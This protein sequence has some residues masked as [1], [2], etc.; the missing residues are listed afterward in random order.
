MSSW[1]GEL[2]CDVCGCH[3]ALFF[4]DGRTKS[5]SWALMCP[6]CWAKFGCGQLGVGS[7]QAYSGTDRTK[8]D[9]AKSNSDLLT[10]ARRQVAEQA[11]RLKKIE[12]AQT[13]LLHRKSQVGNRLDVFQDAQHQLERLTTPIKKVP[14][15]VSGRPQRTSAMPTFNVGGKNLTATEVAKLLREKGVL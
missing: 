4:V 2:K 6:R 7:G 1:L 12:K 14:M 11:A 15:G 5:G 10:W 13:R 3:E 8:L 9:F